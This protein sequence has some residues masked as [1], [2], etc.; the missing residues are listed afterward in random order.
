M[1]NI[2]KF[3]AILPLSL[4]TSYGV[5]RK[6]DKVNLDVTVA[7]NDGGETGY[8]ELYDTNTGGDKWYASGGLWFNG[9]K[10]VEYD[11]VFSLPLIVEEKL[12]E[13]GY[14]IDL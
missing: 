6:E 10:L 7:V 11:G 8:F 9:N 2:Q 12:K 1:D 14:E 3:K 4:E 13:W 5:I